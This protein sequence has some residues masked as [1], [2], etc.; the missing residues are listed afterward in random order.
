M[1]VVYYINEV[2]H[3]GVILS[4]DMALGMNMLIVSLLKYGKRYMSCIN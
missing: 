2:Q 3:L 1:N 4:N